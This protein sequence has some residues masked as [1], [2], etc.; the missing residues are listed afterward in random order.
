MLNYSGAGIGPLNGGGA[1][2]GDSRPLYALSQVFVVEP[3]AVPM[4]SAIIPAG[5]SDGDQFRL[6]FLS[7]GTRDAT[8]AAIGDY[9]TFVQTAAAA[10]GHPGIGGFSHE[11]RAVAS[12][13]DVDARI[14]AGTTGPGVPVYWL[15]G[16][17]LAGDYAGFHDGSW[18]EETGATDETGS[19]RSISEDAGQPW[20]GSGHDGTEE[21]GGG[22]VSLGLGGAADGFAVVGQLDSAVAG[23]GP[24][25]AGQTVRSAERPLYGLSPV[26]VVRDLRDGPTGVTP[27]RLADAPTNLVARP[28]NESVTLSWLQSGAIVTGY[29]YEQDGSGEWKATGSTAWS[30]TVEDL[31]NGELYRFR[32]RRVNDEGVGPAFPWRSATPEPQPPA[33]T[34]MREAESGKTILKAEPGN[35]WVLLIWTAPV[36]PSGSDGGRP[37]THYEYEQDG[38]WETTKG[39]ET[40]Y[41]VRGLTDGRMYTFRVQAVNGVGAS[42][43]SNPVTAVPGSGDSGVDDGSTSPPTAP[44]N[45]LAEAGDTRVTLRWTAP[46]SDGGHTI[47]GYE[48]Q[49]REGNAGFGSWTHITGSGANTTEHTVTGLTNGASYTFRVLAKNAKGQ[50]PA[51]NDAT[52]VPVT[53]PTAPQSLTATAGNAEVRLDWTA[54]S[55]D[56]GS[57]I[58]SYEYRYRPSAGQFN[59]WATVPGSN[60]NTT[61]HGIT[62]LENGTAY[63][64]EVRAATAGNK[65]ASASAT[66]T[67]AAAA[68]GK[69]SVTATGGPESLYVKWTVDNDGGSPITE[70]QVQ[71]KSGSGVFGADKQRTGLTSTSTLIEGLTDETLYEVRV[72][73]SNAAGWGGWSETKSG[74]PTYR[75]P[76]SVSITADVTEPVTGPFRVTITFTDVDPNGN[77]YGV[78]G[79]EPDEILAYYTAPGQVT[80]QFYVTGFRVETPGRVYSALVDKIVDGKLSVEV[81]GNSA[82]STRDGQGNSGSYSTWQV[83]RPTPPPAP[84]GETIYTDTLTVGGGDTGLKGY[85]VGWSRYSMRE[86]RFGALPGKDFTYAGVDYEITQLTYVSGWRQLAIWMCQPLEGVNSDFELRIG[87]DKFFVFGSGNSSTSNFRHTKN[88]NEQQCREYEWDQV[89]LDWQ[90]GAEVSVRIT[91]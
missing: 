46:V 13:A 36:P 66:A 42:R 79:F 76:P 74:T 33:W 21:V 61:T 3:L 29:E 34:T 49:Q 48:Y 60:V 64:F 83:D 89:T 65:G 72:R 68:P 88:G 71:W 23:N 4:S 84:E 5:L 12:T 30:H 17:R 82:Q 14:N 59:N 45:L 35:G 85:L 90:E 55:S 70:Y 25:R 58:L 81:E 78:E 24:L 63:T 1:Q 77:E 39:R 10:A 75:P 18:D 16:A 57:A 50:G 73:A 2:T 8:S 52:A 86:E 56:G 27:A 54:P 22:N 37:I 11:F 9:N 44:R 41:T 43:P 53:V 51:S 87:D 6:L 26:L 7:S 28:G 38:V 47:N 20:T 91:K 67:P 69:P 15:G 80:Y 32:V 62:G 31:T 19:P 40:T